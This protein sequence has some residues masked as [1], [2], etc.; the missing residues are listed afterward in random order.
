M[1]LSTCKNY[2]LFDPSLHT[3]LKNLQ[4]ITFSGT[5]C[6]IVE[7]MHLWRKQKSHISLQE[8]LRTW[9]FESNE[10]TCSV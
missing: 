9:G 5:Q 10:A 1:R 3:L 8:K 6:I 4:G 7:I 2:I